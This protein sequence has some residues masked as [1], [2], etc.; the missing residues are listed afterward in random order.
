MRSNNPTQSVREQQDFLELFDSL[1]FDD[2]A[3][4]ICG[5]IRAQLAYRGTPIRLYDLQIAAIA[6]ARDLS[7]VTDNVGEFERIE[8][9]KL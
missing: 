6:L 9:L 2:E 7:I 4:K 8:D 5:R 3:A 1:S